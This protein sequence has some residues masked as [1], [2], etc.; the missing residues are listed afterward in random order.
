MPNIN[1]E[2]I[3]QQ[4]GAESVINTVQPFLTEKRQE[5]IAT[6]IPQRLQSI[7]IAA[8]SP[9]DPRNAA[10][11]V[12]SAEAFGVQHV[13]VIQAEGR[14]VKSPGVTQG[15][16]HWVH[17]H[18]YDTLNTFLS[19]KPTPLL[20]GACMDASMTLQELPLDKPICLLLGNENRG[21]SPEAKEACDLLYRIPMV[22]FSES[23][24]LSVSA[25]ISLYDVSTRKR[26][27]LQQPGDLPLIQQREETARF[28]MR[29]IAARLLQHLFPI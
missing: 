21:L 5:R 7:H 12:R 6:V 29:S 27:G 24:N 16:F 8:E 11:I 23:L 3:L 19:E 20:A 25:A 13:H 14:A 4:H 2:R 28:M 1:I 22:G 10:A 18:H 9:C 17:L 15:A 26:A